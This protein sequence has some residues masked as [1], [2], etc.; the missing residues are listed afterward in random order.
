MDHT[1]KHTRT[2]ACVSMAPVYRYIYIYTHTHTHTLTFTLLWPCESPSVCVCVCVVQ[3]RKENPHPPCGTGLGF[4]FFCL[5][6][7]V[8]CPVKGTHTHTHTYGPLLLRLA[9]V[10]QVRLSFRMCC[11]GKE[12]LYVLVPVWGCCLACPLLYFV[13]PY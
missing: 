2:C 13:S 9:C 8:C 4:L 1:G 12:V 7:R 6:N 10:E 3:M 5:W 11:P